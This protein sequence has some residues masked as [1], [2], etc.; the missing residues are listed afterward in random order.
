MTDRSVKKQ[1][2]APLKPDSIGAETEKPE[3]DSRPQKIVAY[4]LNPVCEHDWV[5]LA[6]ELQ[7]LEVEGKIIWKCRTCGEI[8]NTYD[9]QIP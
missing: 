9:W 8:T 1:K 7:T 4:F 3:H 2:A 6:D 5:T